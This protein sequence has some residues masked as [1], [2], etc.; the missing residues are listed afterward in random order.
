MLNRIT[1]VEE[2]YLEPFNCVQMND[3]IIGVK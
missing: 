2:Q 1:G 3:W